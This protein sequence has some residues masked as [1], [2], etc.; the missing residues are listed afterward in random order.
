MLGILLG[1]TFSLTNSPSYL[2]ALRAGKGFEFTTN[3]AEIYN[4]SNEEVDNIYP[5]LNNPILKFVSRTDGKR[6]EEGLSIRLP[7]PRQ[8]AKLTIGSSED[9]DIYIPN[10]PIHVATLKL[11][12]RKTILIPTR[13]YLNCIYINGKRISDSQQIILKHNY[14]VAFTTEAELA[15]NHEKKIYRFIYYNR[16][17]DPE[18]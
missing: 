8:I 17:L 5:K 13:K 12:S 1:L 15:D 6:I 14:L 18:A 3:M 7:S 2:S 9:A 10:I 4:Q 11:E 16:F